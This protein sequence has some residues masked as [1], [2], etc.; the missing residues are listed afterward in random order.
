MEV[1]ISSHD[2]HQQKYFKVD[3]RS[4]ISITSNQ[5]FDINR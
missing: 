4:S 1:L 2:L 5:D 3:F